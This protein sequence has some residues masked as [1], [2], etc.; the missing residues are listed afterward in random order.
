MNSLAERIPNGQRCSQIPF[1]GRPSLHG[2]LRGKNQQGL[3]VA[4]RDPFLPPD[5]LL[6][7]T[8]SGSRAGVEALRGPGWAMEE[9]REVGW[10]QGGAQDALRSLG[11]LGRSLVCLAPTMVTAGSSLCWEDDL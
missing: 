7:A 6:T 1:G 5:I 11:A 10:E 3:A 8:R 9:R 4:R 2:A